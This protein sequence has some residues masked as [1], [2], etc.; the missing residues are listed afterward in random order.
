M[1]AQR[2][3]TILLPVALYL[4]CLHFLT[5][6]LIN[7]HLLAAEEIRV[8]SETFGVVEQALTGGPQVLHFL[9]EVAALPVP[10]GPVVAYL[11]G[12][13]GAVTILPEFNRQGA[14]VVVLTQTITAL[15]AVLA[16]LSLLAGKE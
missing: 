11:F 10:L 16:V 9:G 8:H 6:L 13:V 14:G 3:S 1:L 2:L 5:G 12:V 7:K 4:C 15:T